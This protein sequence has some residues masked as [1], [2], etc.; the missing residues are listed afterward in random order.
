VDL[1]TQRAVV[2][3]LG[4]S[5]V[6]AARL[7][8]ARGAQVVGFDTAPLE[9]LGE[10]VR[11]LA[12]QPGVE[13]RAAAEPAPADLRK[14]DLVVISPG[15]PGSAALVEAERRGVEII[16]ELELASRFLADPIVLIGGTN[17]KS[18]VTALVGRMLSAAR[19][20]I[21]VGGNFGTPLC[22][23]VGARWD[24]LVVEISS[25]QAE[26]V[27][28]LHA[29]TAALL[30][31]S[32]DHLDRY[33]DFAA[34][35]RAKG[36]PF[37]VLTEQ[38][39]AV[40]PAGDQACAEQ[41]SRGRARQVTFAAEPDTGDVS[42]SGADIHDRLTGAR[43]P[44]AELKLPG[45]HN[46]QNA[47][48]AIAV[49]ASMGAVPEAIRRGLG[50][51]DGLRHRTELVAE[52]GGVVYYDDSK[53]TNV[54]A[55]VAA[56]SG[57]P[58]PRVVLIAGGRDKQGSYEP[59]VAALHERGRALV[60]LGEAADRIARAAAGVLPIVR[61]AGMAEAVSLARAL[62]QPGDAVLLSP[63]CSSFDMFQSYSQRGEAFAAAVRSAVGGS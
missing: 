16:S 24:A 31:I 30:N 47:C 7:C 11:A 35:A 50:L 8:A 32:E 59:L 52:H 56:L 29:R 33:P 26:R 13:V 6:A 36:N 15:V 63:A 23:A 39:V 41:A 4:R 14:A 18:T 38:D 61:A 17:G 49:A 43:Y 55:A 27:P 42:P 62:A 2:I 1:S 20:R 22:E 5:G 10:A 48:A 19:S 51:F 54:G 3:G 25:F 21:F 28:T 12:E 60:V 44:L 37:A 45:R 46:L 57:L 40:L 9:G 53:G 34:Y 58:Q